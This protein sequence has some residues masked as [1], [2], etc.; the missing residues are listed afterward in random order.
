MPS[1]SG[2]THPEDEDSLNLDRGLC[3][4]ETDTNQAQGAG[5]AVES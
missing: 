5:P 4:T 2:T 3:N 1:S